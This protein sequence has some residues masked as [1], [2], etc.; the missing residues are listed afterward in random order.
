M[1]SETAENMIQE[2]RAVVLVVD[3]LPE[4]IDILGGILSEE[5]T[6]KVATSGRK[7]LQLAESVQPD[8]ILLDIMMPEMDG[9]EVCTRL[10]QNPATS[11]IPVIFVTALSE[12]G[13]EERGFAVGC[14]D[15]LT[16]PVNPPIALARVRTHLALRK[17]TRE[18]ERWNSSLQAQVLQDNRRQQAQLR[19]YELEAA[20]CSDL[21]D[22]ALAEALEL[23]ES[24]I[25]YIYQYDETSRLFT[26]YAWSSGVLPVCSIMEKQTVYELDKTG[27]WGE[28]VRQR[29]AIVTNDYTAPNPH[30]KGYP[31]GH[32][33]LKRHLNLPILRD[34]Q[35][36]AVVGVGNKEQPY[37]ESDVRQ[38]EL[39]LHTAWSLVER[40]KG[41]EELVVARKAAEES[42]R[43]KS[44][45]LANLSHE[46]RTPLNGIVGG[47]QLLRCTELTA[48]QDGY[49]QMLEGA[50]SGELTLINNLLELVRMETEEITLRKAPF[51]LRRCCA[52]AVQVQE[53]AAQ[54]KGLG[55]R[56]ELPPDLPDELVGDRVRIMQMLQCLLGNAIKFTSEGS[57]TLRFS[58]STQE[59]PGGFT[60]LIA[61]QDTG[62]GIEPDKLEQI[63]ELF[64]QSD[65]SNTRRFGGL[66]MGLTVCRRLAAAMGGR[67]WAESEPGR[68][69]TFYLELPLALQQVVGR[70]ALK[71]HL[72]VILADDDHLSAMT[73]EVLLRKL[74]HTAL[75]VSS[76]DGV[77]GAWKRFNPDLVLLSIQL[78]VMNGFDVLMEIRRQELEQGRERT[79]VVALVS[80]G[81]WDYHE[82][83]VSAEFDGLLAKPLLREEL[84]RVL[85]LGQAVSSS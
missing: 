85:G 10:Q 7:A 8:L 12:S 17:A 44:Q 82:T 40:C 52:E 43:L 60:L 56:Q 25:G 61:V 50:S 79:P 13:D 26:L 15:Y 70:S 16:N 59:E 4:N 36:V 31:E 63:F 71:E 65:M 64:T 24:G 69:S 9:Y 46:L 32:V 72:T 11:T 3:D 62:V 73:T 5:F 20:S 74:G 78:P 34:K 68:G 6:V 29:R 1:R 39:L 42:S 58:A 27:L 47:A 22:A 37:T 14:V 81:R 28:A 2:R 80:Y 19:L 33:P 38:L 48:E 53:F 77:L 45:L 41:R 35:I 57:V 30:K 67:V 21:L 51:S 84:E 23:T 18:L 54:A 75:V 83:F 76:G 66:G 55:I 49:L